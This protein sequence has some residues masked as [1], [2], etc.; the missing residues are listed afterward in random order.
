MDDSNKSIKCSVLLCKFHNKADN[1]CT[2]NEIKV[3]LLGNGL[4]ASKDK[5][6]CDSFKE[7]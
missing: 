6:I 4:D 2:L 5:T 3:G 1:Y 7:K